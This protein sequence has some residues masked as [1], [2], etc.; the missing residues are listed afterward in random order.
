MM[1]LTTE[2]TQSDSDTGVTV[3][4]IDNSKP[5]LPV[6]LTKIIRKFL[7]KVENRG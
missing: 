5:R 2:P 4:L 6:K 3:S 1:K 7:A